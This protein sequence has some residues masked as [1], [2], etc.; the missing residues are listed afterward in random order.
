MPRPRAFDE[1]D[2]RQRL[3]DVFTAN[4]Y[5]GTSMAMLTEASGLGKQSLYNSFG[6][7]DALYLDALDCVGERMSQVAATLA[8]ASTGRA[9]IDAF[10]AFLFAACTHP[11][12]AVHICIVSAGLLEGAPN[13]EAADKLRT[14]WRATEALLRSQ[15]KRGQRDGSVRGD[16]GDA[17]LAR[18]LITLVSGLRVAARAVDSTRQLQTTLRLGLEVLDPRT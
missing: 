9:A 12:P 15:V 16:V 8:Q 1:A 4:G 6:D 10:F 13:T 2:V 7:K 3:A 18:V 14:R 17:E 5:Q 11:D